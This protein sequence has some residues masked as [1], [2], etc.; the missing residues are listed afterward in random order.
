VAVPQQ[1]RRQFG[2]IDLDPP[3]RGTLDEYP[4]RL[5]EVSVTGLRV[6]HDTRIMPSPSRR[7]RVQWDFETLEFR[8]VIAR[9]TLFRLAKSGGEKSV[10]HSGIKILEWVGDS[11][12]LIR[13][14]IAE[15]V[16]RALE[17]QKANARGNFPI[18]HYT[19]QVGKGDRFRRCE[20]TGDQW[21]KTETTDRTQPPG[22]FTVSIEVAPHEVE[23][24][25]LTYEQ[26]TEEGRRLTQILAELSISKDEGTPTRRYV[27]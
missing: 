8:C 3:L 14:L 25:C 11:E 2:R 9:S 21:R 19:Y 26:T 15:R 24:L 17:E 6:E 20:L 22:G 10:Y 23:M 4:V 7:L 13:K 12:K 1:E 18:G 5:I 16:I 27:P